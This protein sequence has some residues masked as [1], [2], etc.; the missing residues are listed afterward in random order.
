[1]YLHVQV[2]RNPTGHFNDLKVR[3]DGIDKSL[4]ERNDADDEDGDST[5][6]QAQGLCPLKDIRVC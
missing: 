2:L 6:T 4:E 5:K 3:M 1:M